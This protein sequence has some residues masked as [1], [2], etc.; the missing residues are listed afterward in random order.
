MDPHALLA[1]PL[2]LLLPLVTLGYVLVVVQ[3]PFTNC[4]RCTGTGKTRPRLTLLGSKAFRICRRCAGT[5]RRLRTARKAWNYLAARRHTATAS[6]T[7]R[8][9]RD[10]ASKIERNAR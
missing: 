3:W 1:S 4:R 8:G 6:S 2:P 10:A 5:G 7:R 9:L